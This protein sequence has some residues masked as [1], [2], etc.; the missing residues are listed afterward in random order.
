[1]QLLNIAYI[2]FY[3]TNPT[4]HCRAC[5]V[6]KLCRAFTE[7][8]EH[9]PLFMCFTRSGVNDTRYFPPS[10][11]RA[12]GRSTSGIQITSSARRCSTNSRQ[13]C[14]MSARWSLDHRALDHLLVGLSGVVMIIGR[15]V[16]NDLIKGDAGHI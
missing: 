16:G 14:S 1:M 15:V 8:F 4:E 9:V 5:S 13:V 10:A 6:S 3:T 11:H 12:L 7:H 2:L